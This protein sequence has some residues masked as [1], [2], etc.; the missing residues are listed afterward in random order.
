M[1]SRKL[2]AGKLTERRKLTVKKIASKCTFILV[3][4]SALPSR[5]HEEV[6]TLRFQD[7]QDLVFFI[8]RI[9]FFLIFRTFSFFIFRTCFF[10]GFQNFFFLFSVHVFFA[11]LFLELGFFFGFQNLSLIHISEPTRPY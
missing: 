8:S 4:L 5:H 9:F 11:F 1:V 7:F 6:D 2:T 3:S 10:F